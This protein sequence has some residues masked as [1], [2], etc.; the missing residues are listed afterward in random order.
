MITNQRILMRCI[1]GLV[2]MRKCKHVVTV[3]NNAD[4]SFVVLMLKL[5]QQIGKKTC[6]IAAVVCLSFKQ[7]DV[8][9]CVYGPQMALVCKLNEEDLY[10]LIC[11]HSW[12]LF[13]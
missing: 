6:S 2:F 11:L 12:V 1:L 10:S 9:F 13:A 5:A 7:Y 3:V 8:F 4:D